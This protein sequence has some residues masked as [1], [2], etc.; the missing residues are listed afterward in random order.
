MA[1]SKSVA[2]FKGNLGADPETFRTAGGI[3]YTKLNIAVNTRWIDRQTNMPTERTDW[4][5]ITFFDRG[6]Y[7]LA[8][9]ASGL[10][11]GQTIT[12]E[13]EIRTSSYEDRGT[14]T[15][16]SKIHAMNQAALANGSIAP[17]SLEDVNSLMR[18][19]TR[20][21][22]EFVATDFD[23]VDMNSLS[24]IVNK[25]S[26]AT[27][28]PSTG[29]PQQPVAN[30]GNTGFQMDLAVP[31]SQAVQNPVAT[32]SPTGPSFSDFEDDIPF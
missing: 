13:C 23:L 29:L 16:L 11:K 6:N 17:F 27:Q 30:Y 24:G 21:M 22:T 4:Y 20:Y 2:N 18:I 9:L 8:Q 10:K 1:I 12:I 15:V 5:R 7:K 3:M 31:E 26:V 25:T 28:A 19:S 14:Q 32:G